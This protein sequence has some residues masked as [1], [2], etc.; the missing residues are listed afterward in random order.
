[1]DED[2]RRRYER[3]LL[4]YPR[5]PIG[6]ARIAGGWPTPRCR[7]GPAAC[8]CWEARNIVEWLLYHRSISVGHVYLYSN[9]DDPADLHERILPL[10]W[11]TIP[12]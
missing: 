9:D 5:E 4:S 12:S 2:L 7:F 10:R 6:V 1:M 8:A 3:D 11:D